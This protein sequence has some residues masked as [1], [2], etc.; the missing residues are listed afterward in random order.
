M[1]Y[2]SK[3]GGMS[4]ENVTILVSCLSIG[5]VLIIFMGVWYW[6]HESQDPAAPDSDE[7]AIPRSP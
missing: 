6:R 5:S 4:T 7:T 2:E 3:K 1:Q